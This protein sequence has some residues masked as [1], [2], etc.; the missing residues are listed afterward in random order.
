MLSSISSVLA[1]IWASE[2]PRRWASCC[3]GVNWVSRSAAN[4]SLAI[5]SAYVWLNMS[6]AEAGAAVSP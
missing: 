4:F 3:A 5:A 2:R 1:F 6:C